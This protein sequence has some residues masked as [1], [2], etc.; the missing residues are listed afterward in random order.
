M[1]ENCITIAWILKEPDE[2]AKQFIAYGLG[3]E[4]LLL[5]HA[6]AGLPIKR[7]RPSTKNP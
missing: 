1:V 6:K 3:Q 2:R 5:E 7:S 4:N